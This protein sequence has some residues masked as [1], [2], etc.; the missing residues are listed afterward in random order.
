MLC[1]FFVCRYILYIYWHFTFDLTLPPYLGGNA[2]YHSSTPNSPL[3]KNYNFVG[4]WFLKYSEFVT[5]VHYALYVYYVYVACLLQPGSYGFF[6]GGALLQ[7][8]LLL[9]NG[10]FKFAPFFNNCIK[11]FGGALHHLP[12]ITGIIG[13]ALHHVHH[14]ITTGLMLSYTLCYQIQIHTCAFDLSD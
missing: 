12:I 1:A 8:T 9:R 3:T 6:I 7:N 14:L 13:G 5:L 4:M 11:N 10:W 2:K